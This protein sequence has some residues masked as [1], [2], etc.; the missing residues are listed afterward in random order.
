[1]PEYMGPGWVVTHHGNVF[2]PLLM[3]IWLLPLCGAIVLWAFG[4][5]LK[6]VAGALA[7]IVV[8]AAFGLTLADA[9]VAFATFGYGAGVG[10]GFALGTWTNGFDF[11]LLWDPLAVLWTLVI[12]GVGGLIH[13]YSIGYMAGDRAQARFFAYM[14]F[15]VFAMLT[16]VLSDNFVGLLIGWGLVGLASYFLI[17]FWF[18]KP[19]A[20]AAARKAFVINVVGD[21]GLM[22][23]IFAMYAATGTTTFAGVFSHAPNM[24]PSLLFLL[25]G[26]LFVACAAKSAQLPLH[27]WLPDAMEGPTPVSALI[28]AATMVTAGVY[29]IARCAPLWDA[30]PDARA[31][32]GT[33]GAL[34]ALTGA[35]LGIAQW[36]IKRILAYSTMSQIG[37]MIM[38]VGVG[39]Y[40]AGILHFFAHA[41]FKALLFLGAGLVIHELADEQDV[42]KMGGLR[43]RTPVAF[44]AMAI[45]T[46]AIIG[47]PGFSGFYSKDAV[48]YGTLEHGYSALYWIAVLTAGITAYY[49]FRLLFVAFFG[50][51]RGDVPDGDLGLAAR[52]EIEA[53][54]AHG[55]HTPRWLMEGPVVVLMI[56]SIIAGYVAIGGSQSQWWR[57]FAVDFATRQ[58][59]V[60]APAFDENVSTFIVLAVVALGVLAAYLRYGTAP[61]KRNAVERLRGEAAGMPAPFARA[62]YFDDLIDAVVVR[63]ARALGDAFARYVDPHILDGA[64]TDVARVAG[65]LGRELRGLQTGLVRAYAFVVVGGAVV[66]IAYYAFASMPR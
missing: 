62:F 23:A 39:A 59:A 56:P 43:T 64:I 49:M 54:G 4:P 44:A 30:S 63:P 57:Y 18:F 52:P 31:L 16:L 8:L 38:G 55:A 25:C 51:Y 7:S 19:T 60:A 41:F 42:R 13:I 37:Y 33:V 20:V 26:A 1:M 22:L 28:H 2:D 21:V 24:A 65:L 3:A 5:Q 50:T 47:T 35:L 53:H 17:G 6:R 32:V 34:T 10:N 45:G 61:A 11:G 66:F 29:L 12:T 46:L 9:H 27:T 14:N 15:F 48:I 58:V 40:Q 36:D